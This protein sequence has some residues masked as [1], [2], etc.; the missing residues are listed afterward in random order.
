M[1]SDAVYLINLYEVLIRSSEE[2]KFT[3]KFSHKATQ[4]GKAAD[5]LCNNS[6]ERS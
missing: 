4:D 2:C 5:P 3:E 1:E 6:F